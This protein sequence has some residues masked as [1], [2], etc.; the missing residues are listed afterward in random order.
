MLVLLRQSRSLLIRFVTA[1]KKPLC[2]LLTSEAYIFFSITFQA[3]STTRFATYSNMF[4]I[5]VSPGAVVV[6]FGSG[7][8]EGNLKMKIIFNQSLSVRRGKLFC[9]E[10]EPIRRRIWACHVTG[11]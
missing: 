9:A 6:S 4:S 5:S 10:S 3:P 2:W 7:S 11:A 1:I 8:R